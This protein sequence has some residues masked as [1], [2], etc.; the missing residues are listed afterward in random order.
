MLATVLAALTRLEGEGLVA[1]GLGRYGP[2]GVLAATTP[3]RPAAGA[4]Q[5][6]RA[7][8]SAR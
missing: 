8:T 7:E 4:G 1:A 2:G 3:M 6:V 5:A